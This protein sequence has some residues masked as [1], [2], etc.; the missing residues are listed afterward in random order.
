MDEEHKGGKK[1]EDGVADSLE[2]TSFNSEVPDIKGGVTKWFF[3]SQRGDCFFLFTFE[4]SSVRASSVRAILTSRTYE[5][6][7][8]PS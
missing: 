3:T 2:S 5:S 4:A 8:S 1:N 7:S 6:D